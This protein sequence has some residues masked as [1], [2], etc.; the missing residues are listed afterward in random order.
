L[1]RH[2]LGAGWAV[3]CTYPI[4]HMAARSPGVNPEDTYRI[5]SALAAAAGVTR[6]V[7]VDDPRVLVGRVRSGDAETALLVNCSGDAIAAEPILSG[8]ELD[9][10][11]GTLALEPFGVAAIRCA[12]SSRTRIPVT[13][14]SEGRDAR[15]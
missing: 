7:R 1:L 12:D 8:V 11:T 5:Y 14:A 15:A 10:A 13:A 9:P 2:R 6:P 4:E 3:F